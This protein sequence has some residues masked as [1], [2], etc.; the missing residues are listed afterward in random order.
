M[1]GWFNLSSENGS[2]LRV[3]AK[4]IPARPWCPLSI[5]SG[6]KCSPRLARPCPGA[7][8]S[9][10]PRHLP[11]FIFPLQTAGITK[12]NAA[13]QD[14]S[15]PFMCMPKITMRTER[16][17]TER[18]NKLQQHTHYINILQGSKFK[19]HIDRNYRSTNSAFPK[20][21]IQLFRAR[22]SK[23]SITICDLIRKWITAVVNFYVIWIIV[24]Y[25]WYLTSNRVN[26]SIWVWS[27]YP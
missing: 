24:H 7:I 11:P 1:V 16:W 14:V 6:G 22:K 8:V 4:L 10:I 26:K 18:G 13:R 12:R 19:R 3:R 21:D 25:F 17:L 27:N 2:G 20:F 9:L 15:Q 23:Q 5:L